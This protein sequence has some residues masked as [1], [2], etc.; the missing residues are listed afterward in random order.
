MDSERLNSLGWNPQ[1]DLKTGLKKAY[2]D[3]FA[4]AD[5]LRMK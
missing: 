3:F 5:S 4:H 1:V 2:A